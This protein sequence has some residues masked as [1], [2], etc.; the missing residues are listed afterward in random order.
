M[1]VVNRILP[2]FRK[3]ADNVRRWPV[4]L[5]CESG[6]EIL[7]KTI[8][9][10]AAQGGLVIGS[11]T[12]GISAL[13]ALPKQSGNKNEDERNWGKYVSN[14]KTVISK[15]LAKKIFRNAICHINLFLRY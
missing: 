12:A 15:Y 9:E 2:T 6:F 8:V 7:D 13:D 4:T 3:A 11:V 5:K 14:R 1:L 10:P